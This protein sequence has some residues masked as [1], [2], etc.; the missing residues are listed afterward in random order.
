MNKEEEEEEGEN[1]TFMPASDK[2]KALEAHYVQLEQ[3]STL[4]S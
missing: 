2:R 3:L 1:S 4:F